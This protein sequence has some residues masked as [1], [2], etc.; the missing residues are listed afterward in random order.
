MNTL[1]KLLNGR[2]LMILLTILISGFTAQAQTYKLSVANEALVSP[3]VYEFDI[4]L[5]SGTTTVELSSFQFGLAYDTSILMGGTIT[6]ARIAGTSD[7]PA[8]YTAGTITFPANIYVV[9]G[10]N[11]RYLNSA[12]GSLPAGGAGNGVIL[13]ATGS[14]CAA[15]GLRI[16]RF[17]VTNSVPFR[18]NSTFKHVW[19]T[20]VGAGR[21]N[22]TVSAFSGAN[23]VAITVAA[24]NYNYNQAGAC[25]TNVI[26]NPATACA[27]VALETGTTPVSCFGASDGTATISL[28]GDGTTATGTYTVD[29][30]API[31]YSTNPFTVSGLTAG[32][33]NIVV[34][35]STPCTASTS[36]LIVEPSQP[37]A[38]TVACYETATW[39]IATCAWVVSG[40]QPPMPTGL[41]CWQTATFNNTTCA[42]EVSGTQPAMP[43]LACYETAIFNTSTCVWDV[44]GTQP[45]APT[46][47]ACYETATFN[48]STCVWDV[49]GTQPAMPTVACYETATFNNTT[50]VWDVTGT[51]PPAPTGL[52]CYETATFNNSTCVWDVTGTQPAM[53]TL[54]CYQTATFNTATCV[55]DVTGTQ[56]PAPTGLACYETATFNNTTCVWDVTGT[57]PP[58]PTGLACYET[59]TFNTATC[60]WDVSGTQ[61]PAPTGLACYETATFN[62]STCTW[63]VSGTQ[64]PMPTLACYQTATFNTATCVWDVSGT[65]PPMPTG[66]ACF[67][68]ATFNNNT[69]AW[70]VTGTQPPAPTGLACYQTATFNNITCVWDVTGTQPPA[71]TGLACYETAT[72]NNTTCVWDVTGTQPPAPTGLACWQTATFN[73]STCIWDISGSQPPMPTGLA[74]YQTAT[75]NTATCVWD[76]SGSQP[77][78]PT[79]LA[80]YETATFNNTT[81]V[82]DV[83]GTQPPM[84][85]LACYQTATFN[86]ATCVWDVS[87]TQPPAPT[88]LACYQTATFNNNTC[89]WDVT[90]TQP[91]APT[92]LA[93]WQTA[94]FNTSTCVWDVT[95]SQPPAPTGL[96]CWQTATFNTATCVWDVSGSQ[97]PAPTG[98]ACW[99]TATFNTATCVWDVTGTQPPAPTGLACYQT[100]TFNTSTCVWDIS[101]SPL[102]VTATPS[103]TITCFGGTVSVTVSATG[104]NPPY[105]GT[106]NFMQAAGSTTYTVSDAG[107]CTGTASVTLTEPGKVEGIASSTPANCGSTNGTASVVA[108]GGDGVY[109]YLWS[110]GQTNSTATGLAVGPYTVTITDGT[111]CTGTASTTVGGA[112]GQPD[113]AGAISGPAGAC[114][115]TCGVV[116]SVAP[117]SGAATYLWTL[118]AGVTGS[119]TTNSI[120]L[121]FD[122]TY[123][124]GF[125]CVT[126]EN[127]CGVGAQSCINIP[128]IT[129]RPAQPGFIVGNPNPC[130]PVIETY[131]IPPS[132]NALSYVWSVTGAGV[133]ILSGQGTNTVQ[134]SFPATHGQSVIGVYA[135][136]CVGITSRR[137]TTLT[138]IPTHSSPLTGPGYVCAGS[139]DIAYS[140]SAAIGAGSSYEWSTTG[141]ISVAGA[142]GSTSQTFNFGPS[143]TTGTISVSTSSSCGTFTRTYTIRS[144]A[145]QPGSIAGPSKNL[146]GQSGVTYSIA[147]VAD[148]T[149]YNWTVP[150]G[151][152]IT[153]NTGLS[154]TVDFTAGF[155]GT[156]NICVSATNGCGNGIARCYSVSA[157]T[158]PP[159]S[160]TGSASVCKSASGVVYSILPV[161]GATGYLWSISGG[162]TIVPAGTSATVNFNSATS[163][164]AVITVNAVNGCGFSQPGKKVVAVNLGCRNADNMVSAA[165]FSAYPNPTNGMITVNFQA[166]KSAK[167]SVKVIDLLGNVMINNV[168][169]ATEGANMQ[170]LNLSNVAKGMYLLSIETEGT[171]AQTLRVVVE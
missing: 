47:L 146:C 28:S 166:T 31:A 33:H 140:I 168:V 50:C 101:G 62:N 162:A 167:Y 20:A 55:W 60:V 83:S 18:T 32:S 161:A 7:F 144:T 49:T 110:D 75:F 91:P 127:T 84:P 71:P 44:T 160:P 171:T 39:N 74:C 1:K 108:S 68:T 157:L 113:D 48:T 65:Q 90:G 135:S 97:P 53:P 67:E 56:P 11:C 58:A 27:V 151:V 41:A 13:P 137:S 163:A 148:A 118:P 165:D 23:S 57:Q 59:A 46:G 152:N 51:Q 120:T 3:T 131:S 117:V 94:T 103:G 66:L 158:A 129:V 96:A 69:C 35:T 24:N 6:F 134:V 61:P 89:I 95:G 36:V 17:R 99:Q 19:S 93:C 132:A 136:N 145:S 21:T 14:N 29:G 76:I 34:T 104:G 156:G 116:Y 119:S 9:G 100:A 8:N 37:S 98:L 42:W 130:G 16:N 85:T 138:G 123:A 92:G 52:A 126:P 43:T 154:I 72:F 102:V 124:G 82:W 30:G 64:P 150:A 22:T 169:S 114:I 155:T 133:V 109:T 25:N 40:T 45:P 77:P 70:D 112:G 164:T 26:L 87:G 107:T 122:N 54:A 139:T 149:S 2:I 159:A 115:N 79:G 81:C 38:P 147:P 105:S 5:A 78:M 121:C 125:L 142:Q 88:G 73:N 15:P 4:Y 128:V 80:C 63:D 106:G 10:I 141:D 143:F 170:E 12:S 111:G 153:A 86:T